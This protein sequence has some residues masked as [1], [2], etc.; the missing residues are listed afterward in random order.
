MTPELFR[1]ELARD[2]EYVK[3]VDVK[4]DRSLLVIATPTFGM[5][6]TIAARFLTEKLRMQTV[7]WF[8]GPAL[9][10]V[11]VASDGLATGALTLHVSNVK[12]GFDEKC[13]RLLVLQNPLTLE[14]T[15]IRGFADAITAWAKAQ[16]VALIVGIEAHPEGDEDARDGI[17]M[18]ANAL[19]ASMAKRLGAKPLSG[20]LVGS[21]AAI[22]TRA[23]A[24]GIPAIALYGHV[25]TEIGDAKGAAAILDELHGLVPKLGYAPG[26]FAKEAD[27]L[28][29]VLTAESKR[30]ERDAKLLEEQAARGYL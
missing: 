25:R 23:S 7:G 9:P 1:I 12:C 14:P 22:L 8:D 3:L 24:H 16:G 30:R 5:V 29:A 13:E 6:G 11:A 20:G 17:T 19:A 4:L 15:G 26:E 27:E 2:W 10:P 28:Q 18:A 21:N